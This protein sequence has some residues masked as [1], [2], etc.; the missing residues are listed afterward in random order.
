MNNTQ[1]PKKGNPANSTT[2][3]LLQHEVVNKKI[4]QRKVF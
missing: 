3:K 2:A 4:L 1:S